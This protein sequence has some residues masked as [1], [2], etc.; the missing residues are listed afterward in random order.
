M[1]HGIA[2]ADKTGNVPGV[3]DGGGA[4]VDM[5]LTSAEGITVRINAG[6]DVVANESLSFDGIKSMY[7]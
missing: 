5:H 2:L 4:W 6:C 3:I 1:L 7:R